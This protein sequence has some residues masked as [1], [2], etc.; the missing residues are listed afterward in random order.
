MAA[1]IQ[2]RAC[3]STFDKKYVEVIN[4][5]DCFYK[6]TCPVCQ[7][8]GEMT[9][10]IKYDLIE[11]YTIHV[12]WCIDDIIEQASSREI[13]LDKADAK[14]ILE[15]I[16]D[17]HDCNVGINWDVIDYVTDLHLDKD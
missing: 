13:Y 9:D 12:V 5:D 14:A 17:K 4:K 10:F 6:G 11:P 7:V 3:G 8:T 15:R 1:H 2:C 16:K